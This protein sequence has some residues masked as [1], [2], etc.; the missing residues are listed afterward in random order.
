MSTHVSVF[1]MVEAA[2]A[3]ARRIS[4]DQEETLAAV[5]RFGTHPTLHPRV[6]D[7]MRTAGVLAQHDSPI[8]LS[9]A[10]AWL[11]QSCAVDGDAT[12]LHLGPC[13]PAFMW[14]NEALYHV[15]R[16][17]VPHLVTTSPLPLWSVAYSTRRYFRHVST[18]PTPGFLE[19]YVRRL[20]GAALR[21]AT[22]MPGVGTLEDVLSMVATLVAHGFV[23]VMHD[24]ADPMHPIAAKAWRLCKDNATLRCTEFREGFPYRQSDVHVKGGGIGVVASLGK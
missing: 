7:D 18:N 10:L 4:P 15:C 2:I 3:A 1:E 8:D 19:D 22:L 11:L 16:G 13:R 14:W 23:V 9:H 17:A 24:I 5:A 20:P 21:V 12:L 6:P